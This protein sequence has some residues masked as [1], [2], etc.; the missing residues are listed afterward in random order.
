MENICKNIQEQIPDFVS[1]TLPAEKIAELRQHIDRCPS[2]NSYLQALQADDKLLSNFAQSL[3]PALARLEDNVIN[4]LARATSVK[5]VRSISVWRIIMKSRITKLAAAACVII[6]VAFGLTTVLNKSVST[7]SAAEQIL[8]DAA[9]AV[10][11]LRSVYIKAQMRTREGDNFELIGV[12]YGFIP[13]EMWKEFDGTTYGK[14][15]FEKPGRVVVMDGNS[16]ILLC[17]FDGKKNNAFKAPTADCG[18]VFWLKPLLDIDKV[19]DS[20]FHLAQKEDSQLSLTHS[21]GSDGSDKLVVTVEASAK[22]DFSNDWCKNSSIIESDNRR[23]YTFDAQ[24]KLLE[25][26][27][28]YIHAKQEDVLVFEITDIKYNTDIDPA[29]F[30]LEIPK[31]AIWF[32][33]PLVVTDVPADWPKTPKETAEIFFK[34]MADSDWDKVAKLM[35]MSNLDQNVKEFGSGLAIISIGEPFKSGIYPGWFVP[36][37]IKL[38]SG[39]IKKMNLA[40]RNDNTA[41]FF[42]VDGGF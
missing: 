23:I 28:V 21:K 14:R 39:Y 26:L 8:V 25:G 15:R 29:L 22:G 18:L 1:G 3:Q 12:N 38:K 9:K 19:L 36:Y 13:V 27:Q 7:A 35:R 17:G 2:C 4:T 32:E 33:N 34:A 42:Y 24:T 11:N 30:V 20:E 40:V 6:A 37:E 41:K 5:P 10:S 31:D 16:C